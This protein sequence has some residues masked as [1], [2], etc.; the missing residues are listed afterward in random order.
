MKRSRM[1][2]ALLIV[3]CAT[4]A[5]ANAPASTSA[6]TTE[7]SGPVPDSEQRA[8]AAPVD[9]TIQG[10]EL[11]TWSSAPLRASGIKE[12]LL[13][14]HNADLHFDRGIG[15][16]VIDLTASA[17]PKDQG[18]PL[19]F[20][21]P[22]AFYIIA[23]QGQVVVSGDELGALMNEYTFNFDGATLRHIRITTRPGVLHFAGQFYRDGWVDFA[24]SGGLVLKNDHIIEL[25]ADTISVE[26]MPAADLLKAAHVQLTDLLDI[27]ANGV[28]LTGNTIRLDVLQLFPPP[29]LR[30]SIR[31]ADVTADGIVLT[32]DDGIHIPVIE[33]LVPRDSYILVKGG[34][35]KV[36]RTVVRASNLQLASMRPG[37]IIDLSLYNYRKQILAGTFNLILEPQ[38]GFVGRLPSIAAARLSVEAASGGEP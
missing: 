32:I 1:M 19:L 25:Q 10:Y 26:G 12:T 37:E 34:D 35:V 30:L 33:P 24:M 14:L 21:D 36:M 8:A 11:A 23:H 4:T 5:C 27:N 16:H 3:L 31:Q 6:Q 18:Q 29:E 28:T 13:I 17:Y 9:N 38:I 20:D 7:K 22:T 2:A 15:F